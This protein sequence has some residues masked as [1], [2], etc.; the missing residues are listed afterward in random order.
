MDTPEEKVIPRI[1]TVEGPPAIGVSLYTTAIR[2]AIGRRAEVFSWQEQDLQLT[3]KQWDE[4]PGQASF[5]YCLRELTL[6][7][8]ALR[9]AEDWAKVPTQVA[10]VERSPVHS[11]ALAYALYARGS[12]DKPSLELFQE[13]YTSLMN[14]STNPFIFSSI[15]LV[16]DEENEMRRRARRSRKGRLPWYDDRFAENY[17][18]ALG[19]AMLSLEQSERLGSTFKIDWS[20]RRNRS[21]ILTRVDTVISKVDSMLRDE[22]IPGGLLG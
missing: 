4:D 19:I 18:A 15:E 20:K 1:I 8:E 14:T 6:S 12:M 13:I 11:H 2:Q 22:G 9:F 3:R 21:T 5:A 16:C 10:I 7:L 17:A